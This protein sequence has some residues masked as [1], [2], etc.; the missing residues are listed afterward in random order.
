MRHAVAA[1]LTLKAT[2]RCT[3]HTEIN[4]QL[5]FKKKEVNEQQEVGDMIALP[6]LTLFIGLELELVTGV[7]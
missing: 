7:V 6:V 3:N 1:T 5:K 4:E 2:R